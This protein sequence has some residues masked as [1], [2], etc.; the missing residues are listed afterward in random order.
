MDAG[1]S[2][3]GQLYLECYNIMI[4]IK[5]SHSVG[6]LSPTVQQDAALL[7]KYSYTI[8]HTFLGLSV[9][10][11]HAAALFRILGNMVWLFSVVKQMPV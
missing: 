7:F 6:V 2:D 5:Q 11:L 8:E 3:L 1:K 4:K 10:V 9:N